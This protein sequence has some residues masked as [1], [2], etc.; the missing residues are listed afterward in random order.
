MRAIHGL[1]SAGDTRPAGFARARGAAARWTAHSRARISSQSNPSLGSREEGAAGTSADLA[2]L[3]RNFNA[4]LGQKKT[5][6]RYAA[7]LVW[8]LPV[9]ASGF[10]AIAPSHIEFDW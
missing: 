2:G 5:G 7:D 10:I 8:Q 9:R 1:F 6:G 3:I 4:S